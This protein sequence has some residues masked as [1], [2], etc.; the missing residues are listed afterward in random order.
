MSH[1]TDLRYAGQPINQSMPQSSPGHPAG[2]PIRHGE[3]VTNIDPLGNILP[4][5]R[6]NYTVAP[7]LAA[8]AARDAEAPKSAVS[9]AIAEVAA[10]AEYPEGCPEFRPLHR[11]GFAEK[12]RAFELYEVVQQTG[13]EI[14]SPKKGDEL[15]GARAAAYYRLLAK[16][17]DFLGFVAVDKAIYEAWD[18]RINE[19]VFGLAWTAYQGTAQPGEAASSSS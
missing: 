3:T 18:G 14:G 9:D 2:L 12:A 6:G 1:P 7:G 16:I 15:D 11:L 10:P 13:K 17:D 19:T 8:Q 5:E 4:P